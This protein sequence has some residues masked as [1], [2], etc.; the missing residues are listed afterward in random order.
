MCTACHFGL[1]YASRNPQGG[2]DLSSKEIKKIVRENVV[3]RTTSLRS[4]NSKFLILH[5]AVAL[6]AS[7][8]ALSRPHALCVTRLPTVSIALLLRCNRA[9]I[10]MFD[11]TRSRASTIAV[12]HVRRILAVWED[13]PRM[14]HPILIGCMC[15]HVRGRSMETKLRK[16]GE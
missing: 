16:V 12:H 7:C 6:L 11:P 14:S 8:T 13:T 10:V 1:G 5:H 2:G 9:A 15:Y 4:G 3:T